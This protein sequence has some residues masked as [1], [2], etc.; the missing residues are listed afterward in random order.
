MKKGK[1]V[2]AFFM[3]RIQRTLLDAVLVLTT[4]FTTMFTDILHDF[5]KE[6]IQ[7]RLLR[8]FVLLVRQAT[9]Q[10]LSGKVW[11]VTSVILTKN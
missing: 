10:F 1:V 5:R 8:V 4:E 2:V 7:S 11:I 9:N 6:R 3:S